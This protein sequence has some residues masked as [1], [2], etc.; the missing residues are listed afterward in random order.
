MKIFIWDYV[1]ELTDNYHSDGGLVVI[2]DNDVRARALAEEQGVK[3]DNEPYV[4]HGTDATEEKVY[5]FRDAG[6]C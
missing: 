4:S 2:A 5:I 3:F 6:C 1:G